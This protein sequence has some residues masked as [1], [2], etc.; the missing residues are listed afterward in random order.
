MDLQFLRLNIATHFRNNQQLLLQVND[1][2]TPTSDAI[3]FPPHG[4]SNN[5]D[6]FEICNSMNEVGQSKI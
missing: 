6:N 4:G 5:T 1:F 3:L 2:V